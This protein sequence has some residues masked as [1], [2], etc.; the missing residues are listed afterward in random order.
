MTPKE[1]VIVS[2]KGG[3]G[4]TCIMAALCSSFS[5]KALFCDVDV[6]APNLQL[7]LHPQD[8]QAFSFT[9]RKIPEIDT[10]RCTVCGGCVGFCRFNALEKADN[11]ITSLPWKCEG[12]GGCALVCPHQ[13]ISMHSYEQGQYWRGT[14]TYGPLWHARLHAGEENSGMLVARLKK[15]SRKEALKEGVPFI[16]IDGPPGI[17]CP[18]ISALTGTTLAVAVT[19]PSLSG[20]HDLLR[21]SK[22]CASLD[23][24]L[25]IV[26]N[27]SDLSEA[28]GEE[29]KNEAK[30]ENWHFLG[31]IPFRP[32]VVEAIS[33]KEI[34][35]EALSPEIDSIYNNLT[36]L[37]NIIKR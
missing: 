26:L 1:I 2:G 31:S 28:K 7:L 24:P 18:A 3:T 19:E 35:L 10:E 29:I 30:K 4:K 9:G 16:V 20:L 37:I 14:T 13:A 21:L 33:K 15:E 27:K 6:D 17:S 23:V 32:N 8:E 5:G 12:C 22:L 34:P 25:A 36:N 11:G